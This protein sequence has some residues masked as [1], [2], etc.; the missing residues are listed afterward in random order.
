[1]LS[2]KLV[3]EATIRT[4]EDL[5]EVFEMSTQ[6]V[7]DPYENERVVAYM[8]GVVKALPTSTANEPEMKENENV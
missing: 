7:F 2:A 5:F 3:I 6:R 8:V 4:P 1:V